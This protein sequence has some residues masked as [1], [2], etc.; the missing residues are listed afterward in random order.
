M[1]FAI[2]VLPNEKVI[3]KEMVL[4]FPGNN[5]QQKIC[6]IFDFTFYLQ[7]IITKTIYLNLYIFKN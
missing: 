2:F 7:K 4:N 6:M 5:N 3:K 1:Q